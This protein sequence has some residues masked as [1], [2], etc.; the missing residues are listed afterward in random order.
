M[1]SHFNS[2]GNISFTSSYTNGI[3]FSNVAFT[4]VAQYK[5]VPIKPM[6]PHWYKITRVRCPVCGNGKDERTRM[7]T[8]K[9]ENTT[10]RIEWAS[11]YCGCL[12]QI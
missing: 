1:S 12:G 4:Q 6:K 8:P 9:P 7:Y 2:N 3:T 11:N 10:E 5:M